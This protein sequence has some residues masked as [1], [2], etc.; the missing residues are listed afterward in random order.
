MSTG[1]WFVKVSTGQWFVKVST[2]QWF[3][4]VSTDQH[5]V[6]PCLF[7]AAAI[8]AYIYHMNRC[9][10]KVVDACGVGGQSA[11]LQAP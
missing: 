6:S 2:G 8:R 3:V 7:C 11:L 4:K 9:F 10:E 5:K 1:Q